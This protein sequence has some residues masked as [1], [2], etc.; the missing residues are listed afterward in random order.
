M[1]ICAV[2][3]YCGYFAMPLLMGNK[4]ILVVACIGFLSLAKLG[5]LYWK[6]ADNSFLKTILAVFFIATGVLFS[7]FIFVVT[8]LRFF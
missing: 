1:L 6:D 3:V 4:W 2:V 8:L 7:G 5:L